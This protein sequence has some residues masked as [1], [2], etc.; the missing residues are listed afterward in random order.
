M[1]KKFWLNVMLT[2]VPPLTLIILVLGS[3]I[4]GIATVNQA[5]AIGA[6]GA[7]VMAGYRQAEN[8]KTSFY[9][10]VLV[11]IALALLTYAVSNYTMNVKLINTIDDKI[12]IFIGVLGSLI[13][14]VALIQDTKTI[15]LK[16]T[17]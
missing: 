1:D 6:A 7:I 12:G 13:L 5:G 11:L 9:P 4:S 14:V 15:F 8:F 2:L 17:V 3:I 10:A 16:I